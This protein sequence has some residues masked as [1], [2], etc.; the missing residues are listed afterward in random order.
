MK[1]LKI[2]YGDKGKIDIEYNGKMVRLWGDLCID[3]FA[4]LE[5]DIE[6]I[7]PG[8]TDKIDPLSEMEKL[9]FM[10]EVTK[11]TKNSKNKMSQIY[12]CDDRGNRLK[13]ID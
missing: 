13:F 2:L 12:F 5:D 10:Q 7:D 11:L 6:S 4:A 9:E 1:T 8:N 3:G